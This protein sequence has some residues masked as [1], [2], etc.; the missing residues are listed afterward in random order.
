MVQCVAYTL[1]WVFC[2]Y[3]YVCI[4]GE[5]FFEFKFG[6][7]LSYSSECWKRCETLL[8]CLALIDWSIDY[9]FPKSSRIQAVYLAEYESLNKTGELTLAAEYAAELFSCAKRSLARIL[10]LIASMGFGIVK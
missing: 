4:D 2:G 6:L 3:S 9:F 8:T 1:L 7:V 10:V 5:T